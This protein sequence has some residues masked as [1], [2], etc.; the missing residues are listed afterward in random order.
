MSESASWRDSLR[1]YKDKRLLTIFLFGI[2]SGFPWVMIGSAIS[3][4]LKE[5]GFSRSEI[6][7]FGVV[8]VAY[9]VNFLW[10][11][12]VDRVRLPL[13]GRWLGQ[14]RS[15]IFLTQGVVVAC[16]LLMSQ[17]DILS[18]LALAKSIALALALSAA[19]QDI[20]IDAYRID[21]MPEG[22]GRRMSA[23]SAITTAGW[24]TGYAGLGAV[25]FLFVGDRFSWADSYLLMAVVVVLLMVCTLLAKEPP[26]NRE[27]E[28]QSAQNRYLSIFVQRSERASLGLVGLIGLAIVIGIW[29][30]LGRPGLS[31]SFPGIEWAIVSLEV[32]IV[33]WVLRT[34]LR[35]ER[36][37]SASVYTGTF[38]W[39][40]KTLGWL[41]ST[42]L[43]PLA[44]F[45][46]RNG[47]KL[48]VS[49]LLFIFLFKIGEA[50]L[51][52]MSIVFYKEV[53][54]SNEE[55]GLYS[56]AT[57][58]WV[59][60]LFSIV[61]SMVNIRFGLFRGLLIGGIAMAASNL[62]FA[63]LAM[64]GP[65]T[66]LLLAAVIVDGFTSAWSTVAFV[67]F[68]S[69]MCDRAFTAA[70]YALMASLGTLGR[71]LLATYSGVLVDWLDGNWAVFFV[72]TTLMIIPSLVLLLLLRQRLAKV[73]DQVKQ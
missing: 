30:I 51:G 49:I 53:G 24:W 70:Q 68:L 73:L 65:S 23:A 26:S 72:I 15:W 57:S 4:W 2:S 43:E 54:F 64:V 13:G 40:H 18:Q 63:W 7:F 58:W 69:V 35:W 42:F 12:L 61:G 47:V 67:A 22:D 52:R 10:S 32:A 55:I 27:K 8:F 62:M 1:L 28:Q 9:S 3:A 14:R 66:D 37:G 21:I 41:L 19:T 48:A 44:E 5:A 38:K 45:F 46:R 50:F 34:L 60:I 16:C 31:F 29:A 56:K 59:T 17:V 39:H 6:G 20:A 71:T 11:P 33:A 25:P 36:E